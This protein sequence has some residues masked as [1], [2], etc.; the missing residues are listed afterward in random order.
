MADAVV[1]DHY[2]GGDGSSGGT[3]TLRTALPA[4]MAAVD[5]TALTLEYRERNGAI[6]SKHLPGRVGYG[7]D[8]FA[9]RWTTTPRPSDD[10]CLVTR[11]QR[12]KS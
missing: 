6:A 7:R 12:E 8:G 4:A 10:L 3:R 2:I 1:L 9:G 11:S 5:P